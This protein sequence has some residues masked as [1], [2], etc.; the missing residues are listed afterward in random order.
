MVEERLRTVGTVSTPDQPVSSEEAT[1]RENRR[2]VRIREE[3]ERALLLRF[4]SHL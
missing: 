1:D 3:E 4:G 2:A